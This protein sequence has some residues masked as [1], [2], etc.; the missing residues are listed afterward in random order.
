MTLTSLLSLITGLMIYFFFKWSV[1]A[2]VQAEVLGRSGWFLLQTPDF[3]LAI[4]LSP[5]AGLSV[6]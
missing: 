4:S 1:C 2:C 6:E 3:S 5:A